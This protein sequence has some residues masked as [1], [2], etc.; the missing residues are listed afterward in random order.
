MSRVIETTA[1]FESTVIKHYLYVKH[2]G[3]E[4]EINVHVNGSTWKVLH[5]GQDY[6]KEIEEGANIELSLD[7]DPGWKT[8]E[9][10]N[11]QFSLNFDES[12][13]I[14]F[15][16]EDTGGGGGGGSENPFNIPDSYW[17]DDN[18]IRDAVKDFLRDPESYDQNKTITFGFAGWLNDRQ[19][20]RSDGISSQEYAQFVADLILTDWETHN[21][22]K[23]CVVDVHWVG[24]GVA[25]TI[26][27]WK[28]ENRI[29]NW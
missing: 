4:G 18:F 23:S 2:E 17:N 14:S 12:R 21:D 8:A 24:G 26:E 6:Y 19:L 15:E 29:E 27:Y 13:Y 11:T 22:T 16:E 10:Y 3:G 9:S 20:Y 28:M 25:N 7:P 5:S 1:V